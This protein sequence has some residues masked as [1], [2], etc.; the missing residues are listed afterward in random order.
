VRLKTIARFVVCDVTR[1][2]VGDVILDGMCD[3]DKNAKYA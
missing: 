2:S 3:E 1:I